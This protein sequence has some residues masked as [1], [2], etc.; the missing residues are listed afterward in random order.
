MRILVLGIGNVLWA[1]EGFGVRAVE[2][3]N[4]GWRFPENVTLMDGG[5]QGL[6]LMPHVQESDALILFDAVDYGLTPAA[7]RCVED[8]DVP[9]FLGARKMSLHQNGFQE[10]LASAQ[11]LGWRP[12]RILLI[13]VQPVELDDYGGSLRPAVAAR[14]PEA[15]ELALAELARL[16]APGV[17]HDQRA[18]TGLAPAALD[19]AS[20]EQGRPSA[21]AA[22]RDGDARFLPQGA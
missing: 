2:A 18:E 7:L 22:R 10:T 6:Y 15:C 11:L 20:Y 13:G 17:P 21:E 5:T 19:R 8:A 3:L 16:G 12:Q 1:D 14:V 4:A 9:A